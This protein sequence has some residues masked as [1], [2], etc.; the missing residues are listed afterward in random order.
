[1][2]KVREKSRSD[3][4]NQRKDQ[5]KLTEELKVNQIIFKISTI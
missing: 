3:S 2:Q 5:Q 1:M 4:A